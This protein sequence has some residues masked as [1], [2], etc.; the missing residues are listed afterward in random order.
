M[1]LKACLAS[2]CVIIFFVAVFSQTNSNCIKQ[3][4]TTANF[5]DS[6]GHTGCKVFFDYKECN[7]RSHNAA[8]NA[9][10]A[11]KGKAIASVPVLRHR[12]TAGQFPMIYRIA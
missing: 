3:R 1:K 6:Y 8:R 10:M 5:V 7:G 12:T 4:C 2:T 11:F 9:P